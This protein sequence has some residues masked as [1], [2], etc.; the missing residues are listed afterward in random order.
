[1][2]NQIV[3]LS[4][5]PFSAVFAS[6]SLRI[7]VSGVALG[8]DLMGLGLRAPTWPGLVALDTWPNCLCSCESDKAADVMN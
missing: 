3:V 4:L 2:L 7:R 1:M 6:L 8:D 5:L